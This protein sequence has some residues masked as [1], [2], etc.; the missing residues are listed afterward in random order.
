MSRRMA[1]PRLI[2]P[3]IDFVTLPDTLTLRAAK[4]QLGRHALGLIADPSG[5]PRFCVLPDKLESPAPELT[6]QDV[7]RPARFRIA[8]ALL[9]DFFAD[10]FGF[11]LQFERELERA[12]FTGVVLLNQSAR[13]SAVLTADMLRALLSGEA[14]LDPASIPDDP[15]KGISWER[16]EPPADGAPPLKAINAWIEGHATAQ[17]LSV[18]QRYPLRL[19]VGDPRAGNLVD[20]QAAAIAAADIPENGLNTTWRIT[21]DSVDIEPES[22]AVSV[23]VKRVNG[24]KTWLASFDLLIPKLGDSATMGLS[25]APLQAEGATLAVTICAGETVFRQFT[26]SLG[27]DVAVRGDAQARLGTQTAVSTPHEWQTPRARLKLVAQ[28]DRTVLVIGNLITTNFQYTAL[29]PAVTEWNAAQAALAEPI[30]LLRVVTERFRGSS[31]AYLNDIDRTDIEQ[32]LKQFNPGRHFPAFDWQPVPDLADS[33]HT[34]RW[35]QV[36]QSAE[37]QAVAARGFVLYDTLFPRGSDLRGWLDQLAPGCRVDIATSL[38]TSWVPDIPWPLLYLGDPGQPVDPLSFWGLRFRTEYIAHTGSPADVSLGPP[39]KTYRGHALYWGSGPTD[40]TTAE[41]EVQRQL[42]AAG[43]PNYVF[44]PGS[45]PSSDP[46]AEMRALFAGA[47]PSP[48]PVLYFFCQ[49]ALDPVL[50]SAVLRFGPTNK[51]NDVLDVSTAITR[52]LADRPL[53]FANACSTA[54]ADPYV[55]GAL[56][57]TF[58]RQQCR[59]FLGT[60]TKVPIQFASR[61]AMIFFHFLYRL[62]DPKPMAAGEAVMQARRFLWAEYR[63]LGGLLYNYINHY[64]LFMAEPGDIPGLPT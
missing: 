43:A 22:D 33:A 7:F 57:S 10:P 15:A 58:F 47:R 48:M 2:T 3:I 37:L 30:R 8:A 21:S 18:G 4:S 6:L 25:I 12:D 27:A 53:V 17:A 38:Q 32:R 54:E 19:N 13:P 56:E 9:A 46:G 34:Q 44:A 5:Q 62:A 49:T 11:A 24:V 41:A 45:P 61:F 35:D 50:G 14:E 20:P 60:S 63:N 29:T 42:W 28:S 26:L 1:T 31:E 23:S 40:A 52:P 59:A 51:G 16:S 39:A 64:D 36:R 55:A